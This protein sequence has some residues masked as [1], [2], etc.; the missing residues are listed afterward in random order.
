MSYVK[1]YQS[2]RNE[3]KELDKAE[4]KAKKKRTE[5]I[6]KL[7]QNI[8]SNTD[9]EDLKNT[10]K[11]L[12]EII[13][14]KITLFNRYKELLQKISSRSKIQEF[15][16]SE[17]FQALL[18]GFSQLEDFYSQEQA[19]LEGSEGELYTTETLK[20]FLAIYHLEQELI[21][22]TI[23]ATKRAKKEFHHLMSELLKERKIG[24]KRWLLRAILLFVVANMLNFGT[25]F[26]IP[27]GKW[28]FAAQVQSYFETGRKAQK[29]E[30]ENV[31]IIGHRGS[32][33]EG[34][35]N[36]IKAIEEGIKQ[37]AEFIEIDVRATSDGEIIIFHDIFVDET[38]NGK[39][40]V[41]QLSLE[42]IKQL[43][44]TNGERIPALQ[45][46]FSKF[47][48]KTKFVIDVKQKGIKQLVYQLIVK[49]NIQNKVIISGSSEI[50]KEYQGLGIKTALTYLLSKGINRTRFL[51]YSPLIVD[52]AIK[53]DCSY[54]ILPTIFLYQPLIEKAKKAGLEVWSYGKDNQKEFEEKLN[55]GV[56]GLI[57]DSP[58]LA[59][60]VVE[61]MLK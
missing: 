48:K 1:E 11:D 40:Q 45:E 34:I 51:T 60:E 27:Y 39:G 4:K 13:G 14:K 57:V 38:T 21:K 33:Q 20:E 53:C 61:S 56:T 43:T 10:T 36:T 35:G 32:G 28:H 2:L 26:N 42:E 41:S 54:L 31:K 29:K 9:F 50:I 24:F 44:L 59:K 58:K 25:K 46:V 47:G 17:S 18:S 16:K 7:T 19:E 12:K 55:R 3:L 5:I 22:I 49:N 37:G 52:Q 8:I 6:E 23:E 15:L 30:I